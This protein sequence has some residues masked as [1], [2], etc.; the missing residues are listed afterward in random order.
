LSVYHKN[1][2]PEEVV[3]ESRLLVEQQPEDEA[4]PHRKEVAARRRPPT[5]W[6]GPT[7]NR[8]PKP[9]VAPRRIAIHSMAGYWAGSINWNKD[10]SVEAAAHF[11]IRSSDGHIGQLVKEN[12]QAWGSFFFR[13][14]NTGEVVPE[15]YRGYHFFHFEH[16]DLEQAFTNDQWITD[17]L[18]HSSARLV[19]YLCMTY[20]IPIDRD[21]IMGHNEIPGSDHGDPGP[22]WPWQQYMELVRRYANVKPPFDLKKYNLVHNA[23]WGK[24]RAEFVAREGN[25]RAGKELFA[26]AGGP[27]AIEYAGFEAALNEP[28]GSLV[29]VVVG[30]KAR[31]ALEAEGRNAL[32][33]S[34]EPGG[35]KI[36]DVWD[37]D[38]TLEL[39]RCLRE[40][41]GREP[42]LKDK[43]LLKAY[44]DQYM[45][46]EWPGG[47]DGGTIRG[48]DDLFG[49]PH[50]TR[51]QALALA[52]KRDADMESA[53]A[54]ISA[55]YAIPSPETAWA[56]DV[57]AA[58]AILE[59]GNFRW[60]GDSKRWNL[61][62][63]KK[64]GQ[65]D[66]EPKDFEVPPTPEAGAH[67]Q[68][69]HCRA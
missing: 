15:P 57:R 61:A 27:D 36:S 49:A 37:G 66:D 2:V 58:Q 12:E 38:T 21:H 68:A 42:S 47:G 39:F 24:E 40:V 31:A 11:Y 53:E 69:N 1:M 33:V 60:G 13:N 67:M 56:P 43:G 45:G 63:I 25:T 9:V 62:G 34:S 29:T 64:G 26:A 7:P 32:K 22:F 46:G 50:Y 35:K 48:P 17:A 14:P 44:V 65:V 30:E 23:S 16:E 41:Y 8:T 55:I 5:Q 51:E 10:P 6:V 3:Q 19:A 59:T 4:V 18:L 20:S 28:A 54:A 52:R